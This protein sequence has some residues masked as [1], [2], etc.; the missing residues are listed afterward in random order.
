MT[1]R[2]QPDLSVGGRLRHRAQCRVNV[3]QEGPSVRGERQPAALTAQDV[4]W[5][6]AEKEPLPPAFVLAG[7]LSLGNNL[8][9][10]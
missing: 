3:M 7:F 10:S 4:P 8:V 1:L 9:V 5:A 2:P 6:T